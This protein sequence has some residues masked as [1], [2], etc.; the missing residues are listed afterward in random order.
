MIVIEEPKKLM[1]TWDVGYR[2]CVLG[3]FVCAVY[4]RV[5]LCMS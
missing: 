1:R 3:L 5:C 4:V 2:I